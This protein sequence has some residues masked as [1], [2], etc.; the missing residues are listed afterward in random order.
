MAVCVL[1]DWFREGPCV[2][3]GDCT[4]WG[5]YMDRCWGAAAGLHDVGKE[6]VVAVEQI[7]G[8]GVLGSD[9]AGP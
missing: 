6:F 9:P 3:F 5:E 8:G 1:A 2:V 4:V 7:D